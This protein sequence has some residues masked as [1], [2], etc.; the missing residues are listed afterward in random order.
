MLLEK[1]E[2]ENV[3][4]KKHLKISAKIKN[5]IYKWFIA[6]FKIMFNEVSF[7]CYNC[8]FEANFPFSRLDSYI[9]N[10]TNRINCTECKKKMMQNIN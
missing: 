1:A 5:L 6:R 7:I 8:T 9:D 2:K 3:K 4:L 10:L